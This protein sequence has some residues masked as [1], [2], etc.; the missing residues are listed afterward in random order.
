MLNGIELFPKLWFFT[1]HGRNPELIHLLERNNVRPDFIEQ[2]YV[3]Q[4]IIEKDYFEQNMDYIYNKAIICHHNEIVDYIENNLMAEKVENSI[5]TD[6]NVTQKN[7][8]KVFNFFKNLFKKDEVVAVDNNMKQL[9]VYKII[10]A[11]HAIFKSH[12]YQY[13][14]IEP[15]NAYI[16]K[17][18]LK[19]DYLKMVKFLYDKEIINSND[20]IIL[21]YNLY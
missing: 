4:K 3:E 17:L 2:I 20:K 18:L 7:I 13:M 8:S 12:N 14:K 16:I 15:N 21:K 10:P 19:Y 11:N 5:E 9:L 1:I 6:N